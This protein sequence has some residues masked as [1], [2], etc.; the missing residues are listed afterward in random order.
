MKI[1]AVDYNN[2]IP[3]EGRGNTL[4]DSIQV[5]KWLEARGVDALHVSV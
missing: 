5:C 1:S 4:A 2:V 3:W